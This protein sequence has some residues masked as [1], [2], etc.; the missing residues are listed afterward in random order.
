MFVTWQY[1]SGHQGRSP[2]GKTS[3]SSVS[4]PLSSLS[5]D[6][7]DTV[8]VCVGFTRVVVSVYVCCAVTAVMRVQLSILGGE[9]FQHKDQVS[10]IM[11]SCDY[12]GCVM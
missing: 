3:R 5:S 10:C 1:Y 11:R 2:T 9:L 4:S 8:C 7:S 12:M 6:I